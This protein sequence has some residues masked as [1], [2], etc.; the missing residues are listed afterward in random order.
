MQSEGFECLGYLHDFGELHCLST[1]QCY[2]Y[3]SFWLSLHRLNISYC[4][5]D[6]TFFDIYHVFLLIFNVR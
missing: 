3:S 2:V 1:F 5:I 6:L 4:D